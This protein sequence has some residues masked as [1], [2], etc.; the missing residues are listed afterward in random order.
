MQD[1]GENCPLS[2]GVEHL[3]LVALSIADAQ[4]TPELSYR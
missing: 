4:Y 1:Q 3:L 2:V